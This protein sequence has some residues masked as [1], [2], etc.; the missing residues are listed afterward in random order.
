MS[1]CLYRLKLGNGVDQ[2]QVFVPSQLIEGFLRF[3][4]ISRLGIR[5]RSSFIVQNLKLLSDN[6]TILALSNHVVVCVQTTVKRI[7]TVNFLKLP[8]V[9][10]IFTLAILV[11]IFVDMILGKKQFC[12]HFYLYFLCVSAYFIYQEI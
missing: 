6:L 1:N 8:H 9:T 5:K 7:L 10:V 2:I 11:D 4:T 3:K 12:V